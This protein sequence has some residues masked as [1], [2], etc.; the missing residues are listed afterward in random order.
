MPNNKLKVEEFE[1]RYTSLVEY[2]II[3]DKRNITKSENGDESENFHMEFSLGNK[4]YAINAFQFLEKAVTSEIL[5]SGDLQIREGYIALQEK[6]VREG[7]PHNLL[8]TSITNQKG[9]E[10]K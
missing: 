10:T 9:K 1:K 7:I 6:Q 3:V 2:K 8:F 4:E 5:L